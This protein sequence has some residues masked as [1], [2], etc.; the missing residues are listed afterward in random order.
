MGSLGDL[1]KLRLRIDALHIHYSL[2]QAFFCAAF[3]LQAPLAYLPVPSPRF[4]HGAQRRPVGR[5]RSQPGN[6]VPRFPQLGARLGRG[7]G[8]RCR[9]LSG[10]HRGD[11]GQGHGGLAAQACFAT[12]FFFFL[13]IFSDMFWRLWKRW[14]DAP[15]VGGEFPFLGFVRLPFWMAESHVF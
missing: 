8:H 14:V 7:G 1:W 10:R 11:Q 4:K 13:R 6:E 2:L 15:L 3:L 9:Q 5:L 12:C